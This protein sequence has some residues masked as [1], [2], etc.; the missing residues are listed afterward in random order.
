MDIF[1]ALNG[2]VGN[3][4]RQV[5]VLLLIW[6]AM[7]LLIEESSGTVWK[8]KS[9]PRSVAVAGVEIWKW[10][11]LSDIWLTFVSGEVPQERETLRSAVKPGHFRERL[12]GAPRRQSA[13]PPPVSHPRR[14]DVWC[15]YHLKRWH[16]LWCCKLREGR[17][18]RRLQERVIECYDKALVGYKLPT[19]WSRSISLV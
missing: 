8:L 14:E 15:V 1:I 11:K 18:R 6:K 3:L 13:P 16:T 12:T 5:K 10:E 7:L 17:W 19:W 9:L 4:F 2:K